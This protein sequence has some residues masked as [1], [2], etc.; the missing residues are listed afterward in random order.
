MSA[1]ALYTTGQLTDFIEKVFGPGSMD[2]RRNNIQVV[3]PICKKFK[4]DSYDKKKLAI[5]LGNPHIVHCWVCGYKSRNL[6]HLLRRFHKEHSREYKDEFLNAEDITEI[7][8]EEEE[9]NKKI[10]LPEGFTP[11]MS[12]GAWS[13]YTIRA[14]KYL[15]KRGI[16]TEEE[17]WYWKFGV[18]EEQST[19][20][21]YRIIIPSYDEVGEVNYWTARSWLPTTGND[22]WH[23][24]KNPDADRRNIIFNEINIDWT[25][26]L[27]LVE[28]PFDLIKCDENATA[29]L[30]SELDA[31]WNLFQK[32]LIN[33]TPVLLAFD[34][35]PRAQDK[36]MKIA[37][38]LSE[39]NI[40]VRIFENPYKD[41]DIGDMTKD[42]F[43]SLKAKSKEYSYEYS[44]RRKISK[45]V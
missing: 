28:G 14:K 18:T 4:S 45:I 40:G 32:I 34:N 11:L 1:S 3:C 27:T 7:T 35:E 22:F 29:V 25:K 12:L 16:G 41:K 20:C 30:G 38:T 19:G 24:Y 2:G 15:Q 23:K 21:K 6:L 13:D 39:F 44:L 33:K 10:T 9:A 36:Q 17:L 42:E 8:K 43:L 26:E 31:N 5:K 37:E